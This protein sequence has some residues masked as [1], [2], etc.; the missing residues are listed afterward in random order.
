MK[1]QKIPSIIDLFINLFLIN[2]TY[3]NIFCKK[4]N[5]FSVKSNH[6]QFLL[7]MYA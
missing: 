3:L 5:L 7:N 4:Q 2:K 6:H 1:V